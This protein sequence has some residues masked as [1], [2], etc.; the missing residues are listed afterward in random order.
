MLEDNSLETLKDI[1]RMMERSSRFI[2][3]S[4]L[5]GISAGFFALLG[6]WISWPYVYGFK[7]LFIHPDGGLYRSGN[8]S[9]FAIFNT[10]IFWI[11][12]ATF[13][14]ALISS[15]IF[16]SIKSKRQG[17]PLWGASA[18]RLMAQVAIPI[19]AGGVFLLRLIHFGT[20]GL[21]APGCLIFY[22]LALVNASKYTLDEIKWLG[23]CELVLGIINLW[24]VG[25][26]LYFWAFG[27]GI[28]HIVY[29][30]SM[31]WK[32]ERSTVDVNE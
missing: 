16:T 6:A 18:K 7:N 14:A 28:L 25:Y 24:L 32:Y 2:S 29:G 27:F 9:Y 13:V 5:S 21:I 4:G 22:G 1:K 8:I 12:V 10:W 20:F 3:L 31:W 11:A 17:I 23:Y 26:G 30:G 19:I 15:F